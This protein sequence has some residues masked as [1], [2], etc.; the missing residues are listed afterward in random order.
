MARTKITFEVPEVQRRL[1]P[2]VSGNAINGLGETA[3]RRP[4]PIYW[5]RPDTI[6]HGPLMTYMVERFD[7]IPEFKAI[8]ADAAAR[9]PRKPAPIAAIR[10]EDTPGNWSRRVKDFALGHDAELAGIA[11]MDPAWV[12][13]DRE[14]TDMPWII[15]LGIAMDYD[16][17]AASSASPEDLSSPLEV[18]RQYNRGALASRLLTDWIRSQGWNAKAHAGPWAGSMTLVPAALAAGLGELGK[19]GSIINRKLGSSFRL[20]GVVTDMPLVANQPDSF[21]ADDFCHNC[22]ICTDA[23]PPDAIFKEKQMVRGQTKWFVDFDKCIPYFNYTHGCG[24]CIGEC[25]WSRPGVAARLVDK[26]A[27]R[28]ARQTRETN[29]DD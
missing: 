15:A 8:Y 1:L 5:R 28:R 11:A 16:C 2:E 14:T 7:A 17:I 10:Q 25:P 12:Y 24:I 3:R 6:P 13:D 18:A 29:G 26:L 22:R 23:C 9:G 27:R 19:H 4:S 20:A 21:G